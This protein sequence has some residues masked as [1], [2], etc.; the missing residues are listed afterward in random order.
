MRKSKADIVFLMDA[1]DHHNRLL[2][3]PETI[4]HIFGQLMINRCSM[5]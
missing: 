1:R 4:W 2:M 5:R 3:P